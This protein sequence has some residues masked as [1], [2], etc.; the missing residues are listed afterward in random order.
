MKEAHSSLQT[1]MRVC[2][3]KQERV[4][5]LLAAKHDA[6]QYEDASKQ[7]SKRTRVADVQP[8]LSCTSRSKRKS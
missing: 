1:L 4:R 7:Q 6:N 8:Y 5:G 3:L 2:V